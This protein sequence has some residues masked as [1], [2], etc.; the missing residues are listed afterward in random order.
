MARPHE[1][2]ALLLS[3]SAAALSTAQ[4]PAPGAGAQAWSCDASSVRQLWSPAAGGTLSLRGAASL[5]L[6]A[7]SNR[8]GSLLTLV[9][10][11]TSPPAWATAFAFANGTLRH[12]AS[13]LCAVVSPG[14][15]LP[16]VPPGAPVVLGS[17]GSAPPAQWAFDAATGLA[18]SALPGA[19]L[20]LD[21]RT[22]LSCASLDWA[23]HAYCNASLPRAARRRDLVARLSPADAVLLMSRLRGVPRLGVPDLF[24]FE[25]LHGVKS[26]ACLPA[27]APGS[28]GCATSFPVPLAQAAAF[29]RSLW[30]AVASAIGDEGRAM[31]NVL[32]G[33]A[34]ATL[35][36]YAPNSNPFMNPLW[37]R[38]METAGED[39]TV[40]SEFAAAFISGMQESSEEPRFAKV[41][42]TLKH[43][44]G[45]TLE[46]VGGT[47]AKPVTTRYNFDADIALPDIV[48]YHLPPFRAS[49][50][51]G[52][53]LS[54]MCSYNA[55]NG[56]PMCANNWANQR[57]LRDTL[58]FSGVMGSDC[59]AVGY[60]LDRPPTGHNATNDTNTMISLAV[61]NGTVDIAC[62]GAFPAYLAA[63]IEAGAVSPARL[64]GAL[65]RIADLFFDLGLLDPPSVF[66]SWGAER[67]D[68]AEHRALALEVAMQSI[69]LLKNA[70]LQ[71]G[72]P[73]GPASP[74]LPLPATPALRVAFIG[75]QCNATQTLIGNYAGLNTLVD[76]HSLL[77]AATAA[78]GPRVIT[79]S[80]GCA[81]AACNS[82]AGFAAAVATAAAADAVVLCLGLAP[83]NTYGDFAGHQ[84]GEA[85]DRTSLELPGNQS[86]LARA[87]LAAGVP[88]AAVVVTGGAVALGDLRDALPAIVWSTYGGELGG[89]ALAAVLFGARAPTGRLP[90][91]AYDAGFPATRPP[92]DLSFDGG[93]GIT[94]MYY[95]GVP[96]WPFGAGEFYTNFSYAWGAAA[97][98]AEDGG[99][100]GGGAGAPVE[101]AALHDGDADDA[102]GPAA[103]VVVVD[104]ARFR[105]GAAPVAFAVNVTNTGAVASG[106]TVLAFVSGDGAPGAPLRQLFDFGGVPLLAP[107]ESAT[108]FFALTP[109]AAAQVDRDGA[110]VLR[111]G[112]RVVDFGGDGGRGGGRAPLRATVRL[113]G[114]DVVVEP[115]L[116]AM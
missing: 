83:V 1:R 104:T 61:N 14:A 48:R 97:A 115:A 81:D 105:D 52:R 24:Y 7:G 72:S 82:T 70:P 116:S 95:R 46:E 23:A 17:C 111:A 22:V 34:T 67:V 4:A 90:Y 84:E 69:V 78:A 113:E 29:N 102:R 68:T 86:A 99:V 55:L 79:Y 9:D 87:V 114:A 92:T 5:V 19:G 40:L 6:A 56:V 51:R 33:P 30:R 8:S 108:V 31:Y 12:G 26:S 50:A 36:Y 35:M 98:A 73:N 28:T 44:L 74:L 106:V 18:A 11:S 53:A 32:P 38:G 57:L 88:T 89:D 27:P 43:W 42:A 85:L 62:D 47:P 100:G 15:A 39:A 21:A 112:E 41:G 13:G 107:G 37:G 45:Y 76:A 109:A 103:R 16:T 65:E 58:G 93:L 49:V 94:Y 10:A 91:T 75:P 3:A 59:G 66:D 96:E 63:A 20:C 64:A 2:L 60:L 25:A 54:A 101:R 80:P 71:T 77:A 110:R